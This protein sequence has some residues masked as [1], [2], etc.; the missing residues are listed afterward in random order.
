MFSISVRDHVMIAHS[1]RGELFGPAQRLHGATY[2]V[3]LELKRPDL[4]PNGV[5]VDIGRAISLLA[6]V[7]EPLRYRDLDQLPAFREVNSTTEVL[8]KYV[9]DRVAE[10]RAELGSGSEGL[11]HMRVVLRESHVAFAAYEAELVSP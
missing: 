3:D 9:F 6:S 8:C 10:R 4:D 2:V 1:F 5:V 11:T 7:L